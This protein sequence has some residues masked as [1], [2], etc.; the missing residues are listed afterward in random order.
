MGRIAI[1]PARGGSKR[2]PRK[3]IIDFNGLPM[4]TWT[5]QAAQKSNCFERIIVSTEDAE[6]AAIASDAG[7]E[8]SNRPHKLATDSTRV[9]DVCLELLNITEKQGQLYKQFCCLYATAPLRTAEDIRATMDLIEPGKCDF[10]MAVTT[11]DV[12]AYQSLK[13]NKDGSLSPMWPELINLREDQIGELVVDNGSTYAADV[14]AFRKCCSFYGS[15]LR[16]HLMPRSRSVD[17]NVAEDYELAKYYS[18]L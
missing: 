1:I 7:A 10:S 5:I 9:V 17:I 11:Y 3:N 14:S 2:L 8:V 4:I 12:P 15:N 13:K 6:I 16:G 18:C